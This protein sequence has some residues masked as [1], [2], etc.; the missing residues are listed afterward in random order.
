[1]IDLTVGREYYRLHTDM[2]DWCT[3]QFGTI[4]TTWNR[5][6]VFGNQYYTFENDADATYFALRWVKNES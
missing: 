5:Q 3:E 1:M 4:T 2:F 6:M